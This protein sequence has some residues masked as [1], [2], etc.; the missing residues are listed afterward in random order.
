MCSS[1][2]QL[3][4]SS[5]RFHLFSFL[6]I[7]QAQKR[8]R[9]RRKKIGKTSVQRPPP[10]HRLHARKGN[11]SPHKRGQILPL[12]PKLLTRPWAPDFEKSAGAGGVSLHPCVEPLTDG[13]SAVGFELDHHLPK[14]RPFRMWDALAHWA[15]TA[16]SLRCSH[17]VAIV[18]RAVP[19]ADSY[20]SYHYRIVALMFES[21]FPSFY[22]LTI[23]T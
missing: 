19:S 8:V 10:T 18:E 20:L 17:L 13:S 4:S 12:L 5:R 23:F 14:P 3:P 6:C 11:I 15:T 16:V 9:E 21:F 1:L 22:A 2:H 7:K